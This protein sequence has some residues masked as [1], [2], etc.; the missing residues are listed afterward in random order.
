MSTDTNA[1]PATTGVT[2]GQVD[3]QEVQGAVAQ[4]EI[5][6]AIFDFRNTIKLNAA[7]LQI[8]IDDLKKSDSM[9]EWDK[10]EMIANAILAYRHLEDAGMRLGKVMQAKNGGKSILTK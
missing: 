1:T 5:A 4:D 7:D 10:G 8:F 6:N 2:D 9:E 3:P